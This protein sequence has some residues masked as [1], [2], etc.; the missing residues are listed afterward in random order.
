MHCLVAKAEKQRGKT[1]F[2]HAGSSVDPD[3]TEK[4]KKRKIGKGDEAA[5][6]RASEWLPWLLQREIDSLYR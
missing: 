6:A 3:R 5:P 4:R 2:C 1:A